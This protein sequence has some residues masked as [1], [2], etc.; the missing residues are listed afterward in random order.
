MK[1]YRYTI[2]AAFL[3]AASCP[4]FA[5]D[6]DPTVVVDRA[7]EGKLMEVHKPFLEMQVP[8]SVTRFDLDFDYSVFDKPYRGAYEFNPYVLTMR[9]ASAV[10]APRQLYLKAGA[11]YTLH[12]LLDFVWALPFDEAFRM[13]VYGTH[14]SYVGNY[15][16]FKPELPVDGESL[17]LKEWREAGGDHA[18]RM[19]YDLETRAGADASYDWNAGSVRLDASYYGLASKDFLKTRH[20]DALDVS[21]GVASKSSKDTYFMYDM[22][23]RYRFGVDAMEYAGAGER[24]GEHVFALDA[25]L[26]QV[27]DRKHNVL[28]DVGVE[29]AAYSHPVLSTVA[30]EFHIVPHYV[31]SKDRWSVDAGIRLAKVMRSDTP[32]RMFS[33]KDQI[34]YP[35]ISAWFDAI[36]DAMRVYAHVGGGNRLDSYS[37]IMER[38]HHFDMEFGRGLWPLMDFTVERVGTR[39]GLKGRIG[40]KFSYDLGAGYVNY[41]NAMLDAVVIGV[42]YPLEGT[43]HYLPAMGYAPYQ[44]F[45]VALGW[46]WK[47]ENLRF[48]GDMEY[49]YAFGLPQEGGLFAPAA[50]T[51]DVAFEYNWS[52]RIYAGVDCM[53]STSRD[54]SVLDLR[55]GDVLDAVIPGYA[56][57]GIYFEFATS[58]TLSFWMRG[59]NLLNMTIQR[60]PLYSEKGLNFTLGVCLNL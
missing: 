51:G 25:V 12:P 29:L 6:L 15:R 11:G 45:N 48:E 22:N 43:L 60:N 7:Y 9:P 28:F 32:G 47:M 34:V 10:E 20:Y 58:R 38:N 40:P 59:G 3:M 56:D 8:D 46:N 41:A 4:A 5:Q 52:R 16:A 27:I 33:A 55:S 24:L 53:F 17:V 2:L 26:G 44:K 50:F 49:A 23:A 13:N 1:G 14:R 42:P 39:I 35:D 57:L 54:G 19:G 31:F 30:G 37:S 36:P 18:Y 21:A